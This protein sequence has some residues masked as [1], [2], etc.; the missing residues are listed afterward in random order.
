MDTA[1][2]I[3]CHTDNLPVGMLCQRGDVTDLGA[4]RDEDIASRYEG[5]CLRCCEHNHG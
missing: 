2:C 3:R 5:R 4:D 1:Y